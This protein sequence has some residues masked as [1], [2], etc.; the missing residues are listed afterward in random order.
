VVSS[1]YCFSDT[2]YGT[3]DNAAAEGLSWYTPDVLPPQSGLVVDGLVYQYSVTKDPSSDF[4]V[5]VR[6]EDVTGQS[7]LFEYEDDWSQ[8]PGGRLTKKQNFSPI[9][10]ENWGTGEI[11]TVGEGQVTDPFVTYVYKYDECYNPL[12]DPSC[13][14]Y[15]DALYQYLLDNGL[16][17]SEDYDDE[18]YR[19]WV[20]SQEVESEEE[21]AREEEQEEDREIQELNGQAELGKLADAKAFETLATTPA[22]FDSYYA[23]QI[24]GGVYNEV[25]ELQDSVLPDN[26]KAM[27]NLA[28]DA[29]HRSMVRSQYERRN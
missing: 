20:E 3:T 17:G 18:Y 25:V 27:R 6:N 24:P 14:G 10:K 12:S 7:Y 9:P 13:P 1:S 21:T 19:A 22:G 28:S 5:T 23:P 4:S 15:Y 8:L 29:N 2:Q 16:L 11:A 26:R